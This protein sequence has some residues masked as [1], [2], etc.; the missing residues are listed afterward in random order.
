MTFEYLSAWLAVMWS[1]IAPGLGNHLW[2]STV[3]VG[4]AALLTLALRKNHARARYW[5]WLSASLKFLIPFS[6]LVSL[7]SR[8]AWWHSAAPRAGV[9]F[10]IEEIVRPAKSSGLG[11][12][13]PAA[14]AAAWLCGVVAIISVWCI[15]W[16]RISA[17]IRSAMPL[18]DGREA[19]L[20]HRLQ[21][22]MDS[23]LE[24]FSSPSCLEPGIFGIIHPV[25]L[26]P[27][28]ISGRLDDPH[29]QTILEHEICHVRR[30]DNLAATVH[31]LVE[32]IFWF[33]PLVWW[34]GARLVEERERA[35]D[36]DV[37][38]MGGDKHVYAE[39][40]LKV[41][42]FCIESPL[43][44]VSGVTGADLKKRMVH[45]MTDQMTH[46]LNFTRRLM[47]STAAFLAVALP[48]VFGLINATPGQ[49][50][51]QADSA[52]EN[53]RP[54]VHSVRVRGDLMQDM[55][56]EK[57][58]PTYPDAARKA[59]I[60]GKVI[61]ATTISKEGDV[62]NIVLKS[63]HPL[64]AP[65]AIE[66]VKQWKYKPY[67]LNGKPVAVETRVEVNFTLAD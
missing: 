48:V 46:K 60:Q 28:G 15:R 58:N 51:S 31:M 57:V 24:M 12:S 36:E 33:H 2:Q 62:E 65:A 43:A 18:H 40:I 21:Q 22:G 9:Y 10:V 47:L 39:S 17:A 11:F 63:G 19:E 54:P 53:G 4:F 52:A 44:C 6:L 7:G 38:A 37:L 5:L 14:L 67:I 42:E 35:C 1:R 50:Q 29:L 49:A 27:A 8:L 45:I 26:W 56:R 55:I 20:L 16:R 32:A 64:L 66:A 3:F 61:L 30:R 25:L 13:V 59:R 23:K 41:C 34:V